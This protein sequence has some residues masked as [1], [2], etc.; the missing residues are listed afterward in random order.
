MNELIWMLLLPYLNYL[1]LSSLQH[2]LVPTNTDVGV[3]KTAFVLSSPDEEFDTTIDALSDSMPSTPVE[4]DSSVMVPD[5]KQDNSMMYIRKLPRSTSISRDIP[6]TSTKRNPRPQLITPPITGLIRSRSNSTHS[7]HSTNQRSDTSGDRSRLK[8]I[9]LETVLTIETLIFCDEHIFVL[10]CQTIV[11]Q[12]LY[13]WNHSR[14]VY[15]M[16]PTSPHSFQLEILAIKWFVA[17][18]QYEM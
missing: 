2:L 8:G 13:R 6:P 18:L 15:V 7:L 5:V 10:L 14:L 12:N 17:N 1:T 3:D 4:K 9:A 11:F 16:V